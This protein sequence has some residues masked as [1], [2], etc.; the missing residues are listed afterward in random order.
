MKEYDFTLKF[1]LQDTQA[2]ADNYVERLYAGGCDDA[3]IGVGLKGFISLNFIREASSAYEAISSAIHD[4]K[5]VVPSATLIEASPDFVG[6]TDA[7]NIV[8]CSRQ[9][10]RNLI[11]NSE[12]QSP[13]PV[14]EG[15]P[16]IWHLGEI[17]R[18]LREVKRYSIDDSL[19]EVAETTMNL[20]IARSYQKIDPG[21]QENIKSLVC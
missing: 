14:Y 12:Q 3:L 19:L 5:S 20:N 15:T 13:P 21:F 11:V 1:N 7:A 4:V 8:G 17:L 2:D 18:W 16:S 6:L 10:M 9:N